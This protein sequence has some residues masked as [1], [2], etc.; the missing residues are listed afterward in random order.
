LD[1]YIEVFPSLV[2]EGVVS[3]GTLIKSMSTI[4]ENVTD[5][6]SESAEVVT[7]EITAASSAIP[8]GRF[9]RIFRS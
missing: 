2:R 3:I 6:E 4:I 9:S 1:F 8:L 7:E 5:L